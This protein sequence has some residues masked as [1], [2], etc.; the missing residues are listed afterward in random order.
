VTTITE[1]FW[2]FEFEWQVVAFKGNES[3]SAV[4]LQGRSGGCEIITTSKDSPRPSK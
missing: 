4:V 2:T 1:W 3:E